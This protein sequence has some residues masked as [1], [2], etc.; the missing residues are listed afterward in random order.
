MRDVE[1]WKV[2]LFLSQF[3]EFTQN[4]F[5]FYPRQESLDT[6]TR[7]GITIPQA[8]KEIL[9]LTYE[10]YYRGPIP[11]KD[12]KGEEFWE[13]GKIICGEEIFIKL[14]TVSK[15]SVAVC[16]SFHIPGET[17]EYPYKGGAKKN[18]R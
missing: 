13:F 5:S 2:T 6:I 15:H 3:K 9:G 12:H 11:D 14:K 17:I 7:L 10:D 4:V 1:R 16:F 8:K 18:E